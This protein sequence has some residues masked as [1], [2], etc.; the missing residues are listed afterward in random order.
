MG[1]GG[2]RHAP[3]A[4][5]PGKT[6]YPL[7]RRLAGPRAS[8]E[9][10]EKSRL[11][12]DSNLPTTLFRPTTDRGRLHERCVALMVFFL[13]VEKVLMNVVDKTDS[14]NMHR[15]ADMKCSNSSICDVC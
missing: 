7:Y 4:L 13:T 3:A 6:R 9:G 15:R 14:V 10:C 2:Q 8:L 1:V 11:Y 5:P 12:R